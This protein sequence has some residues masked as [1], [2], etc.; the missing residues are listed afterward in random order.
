MEPRTIL[1]IEQLRK[2]KAIEAET[3]VNR[4]TLLEMARAGLIPHYRVGLKS[5]GVRFKLSEVLSSLKRDAQ[6]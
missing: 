4:V 3:G 6:Q 2:A 1:P 5:H